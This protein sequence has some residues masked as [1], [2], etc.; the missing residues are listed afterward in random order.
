MGKDRGDVNRRAMELGLVLSPSALD[1]IVEADLDHEAVFRKAKE[2]GEWLISPEL[3][4]GEADVCKL[5]PD[6]KDGTGMPQTVSRPTACEIEDRLI[7]LE[8]SDVTGQSTCSG[9]INDFIKYF[10]IRFENIRRVIQE[11]VEYR[12]ARS[13]EALRGE[14]NK[15]RG[16]II[17]MVTEKRESNKGNKFLDVEDPT[18]QLT[19]M[20]SDREDSS[21]KLYERILPDEVIGL[22]GVLT[23]DLFIANE[24]VQPDIPIAHERSYAGEEVYA[25]FLSDIHIGSYLFLE[26]EFQSFIKWL[27]GKGNKKDIA[28]KVKYIFIAGDLVDGIGIYPGQDKELIITDIKKQYEFL[29]LLLEEIP[30]HI[31]IVASVGNHD[32]VRNAEPQPMVP[33]DLAPSLHK[34]PNVHL[35]GNPVW[36]TAHGV[37]ILMYHGTSLDTIIGNLSGC[38]YSQPETG[39]IEYLKRRNLIPTYGNDGIAQEEKDFLFIGDVPDIFHCGHVHTNGFALYRGVNVINSGTWQAKTAFQERLG[40]QPTPAIVPVMNLANHE[41]VMLD[42][43]EHGQDD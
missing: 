34:M 14:G 19:V 22:D 32:A 20:V 7:V 38:S 35:C 24:I 29:A 4:E 9:S 15:A 40:H 6:P 12:G 2:N 8:G 30:P 28:E 37:K 21:I 13:I 10:N 42:F 23:G 39:M 16:R 25:A 31:Q 36:V 11:R 33:K 26:K 5:E 17:V 43:N 1:L 18:G 3:I 41:M 27:S